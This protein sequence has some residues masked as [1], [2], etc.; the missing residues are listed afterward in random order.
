ML[1]K[2]AIVFTMTATPFKMDGSLDEPELRRHLRRLVE[3]KNGV[4]LAG[5]GAG[6]G[7]SLTLEEKKRI[8]EIGVEECKG[9][10][11]TRAI[12]T[13][14]RTAMDMIAMAKL[15]VAA[16]VDVLQVYGVDAGHGTRPSAGEQEQYYRDVLSEIK[17]PV[18]ISVHVALGYTTPVEVLKKLTNEYKQIVAINVMGP[19]I[20]YFVALRDAVRA[21]VQLFSGWNVLETLAL[22]GSGVLQ[23]EGNLCPKLCRSVVD[24]WLKKDMDK[25]GEAM[26]N[27]VRVSNIVNRWAPSTARWAKMGM[28][29]LGL[30]GGNGVLRRPYLLPPEADQQE[31]GR[32]F[33]EMR[34]KEL[35]GIK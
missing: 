9:K 14:C 2:D 16:N 33:R 8:Y 32:L 27:V 28:K 25:A 3:A 10:I 24:H 34:L 13:E 6:E 11:P 35:E 31:M 19:P 23:A 30:P 7:H 1:P 22:G 12:P 5:G 21:D 4:Y 20:S 29:V 15:A 18:A 17:H 26:A